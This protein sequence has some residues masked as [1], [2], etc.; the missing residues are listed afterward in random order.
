[1]YV[2]WC[3]VI[4]WCDSILEDSFWGRTGGERGRRLVRLQYCGVDTRHPWWASSW[5]RHGMDC[6][7][8]LTIW[9]R[10]VVREV[11]NFNPPNLIRYTRRE[12]LKCKLE[13]SDV[14]DYEAERVGQG[15]SLSGLRWDVDSWYSTRF[16]DLPRRYAVC[17]GERK[18]FELECEVSEEIMIFLSQLGFKAFSKKEVGTKVPVWTWHEW[19]LSIGHKTVEFWYVRINGGKGKNSIEDC[20]CSVCQICWEMYLSL[21]EFS[22]AP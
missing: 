7:Q 19:A 9:Q 22:S 12:N 5:S 14:I 11:K 6:I 10:H 8:S 18:I 2:M 16:W 4:W 15:C 21:H 17:E 20:A 13:A 3:D 1:M